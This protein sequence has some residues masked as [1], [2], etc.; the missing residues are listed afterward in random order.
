MKYSDK[1]YSSVIQKEKTDLLCNCV[2]FSLNLMFKT[3]S[4]FENIEHEKFVENDNLIKFKL[5][6][7]II[8]L[9]VEN[10]KNAQ[11]K[12][13]N[14]KEREFFSMYFYSNTF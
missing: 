3:L 1:A 2:K 10:S 7:K 6:L 11:D 14:D 5:F 13:S 12:S 8:R 9:V 4:G